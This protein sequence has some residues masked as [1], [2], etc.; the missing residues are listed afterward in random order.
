M[1][2]RAERSNIRARL[3]W[4]G[5]L[6]P[7]G[8]GFALSVGLAY[9]TWDAARAH[10]AAAEATV[11][12]HAT[13]AAH[14]LAGRVDRRMSQAMLYAFYRVDLA[15][16]DGERWPPVEG[17]A[18]SQELRR[19]EAESAAEDRVFF[20]WVGGQLDIEGP[21]HPDLRGWLE[22][23]VSEEAAVDR[24]RPYGVRFGAP[25]IGP[26]GVAYRV[27]EGE[28]GNA[29]YGLDN[30]FRDLGGNVFEQSIAED[31]VLPPTLVGDTP[32]D[33]LF[34]VAAVDRAGEAVW[35]GPT[36]YAGFSGRAPV[37]PAAAYG[38]LTIVLRLQ[39]SAMARLVVGGLPRSRLPEAL[40]LVA[41]T[42]LL[43]VVA[44]RQL[45][46]GQELIRLREQ[47]V[48]NV[49]HELRTPLQQVL[50]FADL[51]RLK[52]VSSDE[53]RDQAVGV[54]HRETR[55][56]INLVE[57]VLSFSRPAGDSAVRETDVRDLA[58][59]VIESFAPIAEERAVALDV[60]G[61][62]V[63]VR[64]DPEALQRVLL[65]LLDNA[66]KYGP[67]GQTVTIHVSRRGGSG[68]VSVRDEGPGIPEGERDR[69]W[70]A[71]FRLGREERRNLTGQGVGLAIVRDL[72]ERMGGSVRV[73]ESSSGGA[74]FEVELPVSA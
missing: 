65:N 9:Q 49:S 14:L 11:R 23:W 47:F 1:T 64:G 57:N 74:S 59:T 45:R 13:F 42:A 17:L 12:D 48:R 69:I 24:A 27:F 38:G 56:L 18:I 34:T 21:A 35:G 15:I 20:R 51:L 60:T 70:E 67:D 53:E 29:L 22:G 28:D 46:R 8:L 39:D 73:G 55:R 32:G 58:E 3:P 6:I 50:L 63:V 26:S 44:A 62:P 40:G 10:R 54:I 36:A 19:C 16:R 7:L 2:E 4:L 66:V 72:V 52:R 30:C 37:E 61:E 71:Y 68:V 41:L 25:G 43:F 5:I 33:S 31:G